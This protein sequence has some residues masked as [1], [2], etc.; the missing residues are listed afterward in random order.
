ML[1]HGGTLFGKSVDDP[2]SLAKTVLGIMFCCLYGGPTFLSKMLPISRL[3][4]Q[5]LSEQV[6]LSID[7]VE[8]A[9][10]KVKTIIYDGNTVTE[11]IKLSLKTLILF[12]KNHG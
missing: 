1:Y 10:A 4:S 7:C 3:N 6:S 9:G 12:Q 2:K 8:N 11:L 5:F